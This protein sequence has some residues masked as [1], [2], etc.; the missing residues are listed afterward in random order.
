MKE[1][2]Y[3]R[4]IAIIGA[5][6]EIAKDLVLM[7]AK[8]DNSELVL[9]ARRHENVLEWL[10][11]NGMNGKYKVKNLSEFNNGN[12]YDSIIN[13]IGV[14]DPLR[15]KKKGS[16]IFE[17]TIKYDK[18]ILKY[19]EKNQ[20]CRYIFLSSGAVYG[21]NFSEPVNEKSYSYFDINNLNNKSW[22]GIAKFYA[23]SNHRAL[24]DYAIVD[25]RIFNYF[26]HMQNINN[27]YFMSQIVKAITEKKILEVSSE[28]IVRDYIMP[29]D[30]FNL[31]IGILEAKKINIAIDCY[32][33][34]P[35]EKFKLLDKMNKKFGL[36]YKIIEEK[37]IINSTGSKK[38]Y[39]SCNRKA[40]IFGYKPENSS[41]NNL[42]K[43]VQIYLALNQVKKIINKGY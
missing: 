23:E 4:K 39:Y 26:S 30:F 14:G 8:N 27:N 9:Y 2:A 12:Y 37:E 7:F 16:S 5:T 31:I 19:L 34:K 43:Q 25:I 18:M 33:K 42:V 15:T 11:K 40:E 17:L 21:E 3:I 38:N 36:V 20:D 35:V 6:S 13:F 41:I 29:F 32:S 24:I 10:L 22:Y 1:N 28:N